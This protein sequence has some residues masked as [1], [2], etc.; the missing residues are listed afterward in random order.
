MF[1]IIAKWRSNTSL[2]ER[3]STVSKKTTCV[4]KA[5]FVIKRNKLQIIAEILRSVQN[6]KFDW[7]KQ[8]EVARHCD[9]QNSQKFS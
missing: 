9:R 4:Y 3:E 5:E 7:S 6:P 1:R 2:R 8:C